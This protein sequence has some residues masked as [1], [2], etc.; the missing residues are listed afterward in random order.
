MNTS[1][2]VSAKSFNVTFG[3]NR[4]FESIANL[5]VTVAVVMLLITLCTLMIARYYTGSYDWNFIY[6]L[7][8]PICLYAIAEVLY[9]KAGK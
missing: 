3:T 4:S 1:K 5:F 6:C 2:T 8:V 7:V 9:T